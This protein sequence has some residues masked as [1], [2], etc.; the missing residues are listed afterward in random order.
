MFTDEQIG[1]FQSYEEVRESGRI[2]MFS[3]SEGCSLSGLTKS[4][5]L[6]VMKNYTE[7]A[8]EDAKSN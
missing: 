5:Y 7:L 6:F 3:I 1:W 2:N 4:Q 8:A